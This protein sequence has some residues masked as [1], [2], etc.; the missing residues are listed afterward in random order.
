MTRSIEHRSAGFTK[1]H[2]GLVVLVKKCQSSLIFYCKIPNLC[3]SQ[4][5]P[6]HV[7]QDWQFHEICLKAIYK[8]YCNN[9]A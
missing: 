3:Q 7:G 2:M 6:G 5:F 9:C 8:L 4:N 1:W